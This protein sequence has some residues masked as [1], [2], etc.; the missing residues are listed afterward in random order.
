[1]K[2]HF[3]KLMNPKYV[4]SWDLIAADN[5]YKDI[6]VTITEVVQ[7]MVHN[8]RGGED[9]CTVV[10]FK[11]CKPLV[12]N[13]TNMRA[14]KRYTGSQFIEDWIGKKITLTVQ[15]VKAFGD[16]HDAI[17]VKKYS[18]PVKPTIGDERFKNAIKAIKEK[19]STKEQLTNNFTLTN[20]QLQTLS[21]VK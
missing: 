18:E 2:T 16:V 17:R 6:T 8:G 9:M 1:M 12:A 7:E 19:K 13:S 14:I 20:E 11:E 10:R 21:E 3:R 15:Q 4:G 5:T